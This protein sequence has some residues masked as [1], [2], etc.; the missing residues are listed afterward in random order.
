ML[1]NPDS[2]PRG[3]A[4]KLHS[5][6]LNPTGL[7]AGWRLL[8]FALVFVIALGGSHFIAIRFLPVLAN[9]MRATARQQGELRATGLMAVEGINLLALLVAIFV[10]S[11]IE[12]RSIFSYGYKAALN[13]AVQRFLEGFLWGF[14]MITAMC[15]LL[16]FEGH[17][18]FGGIALTLDLAIRYG[19]L[20]LLTNVM[21]GLFEEGLFRGYVQFT[22]ASG[23]GFWPAAVILSC[24]FG[25]THLADRGYTWF[26]VVTAGLF[27][28]LACLALR[29]TGNLW[30]A[31]GIH[32]AADF[33]E[34]FLF[35]PPNGGIAQVST[36][37]FNSTV[38]GPSWLSGGGTGVEASVNGLLV[39]AITFFLFDRFHPPRKAAGV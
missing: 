36:H 5:I 29:R 11:R 28:I 31:I 21:V 19:F 27:G 10:M 17:F 13:I 37:L 25:L 1:G 30:L 35:S 23:I 39:F 6:F 12:R 15:A 20:W 18:T 4:G 3:S 14:L 34:T 22:L 32:S 7:R 16:K 8:L 33:V 2:L 26:G 24:M 38:S 9:L